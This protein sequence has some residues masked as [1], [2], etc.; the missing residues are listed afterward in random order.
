MN[1]REC[2]LL[3][4]RV[5]LD[6]L[7]QEYPEPGSAPEASARHWRQMRAMVADPQGWYRRRTR[8]VWRRVLRTAAM[9]A[10]TLAVGASAL[11]AASPTIRAA[12]L[13]WVRTT[14][15]VVTE[16]RFFGT[17]EESAL[18]RY[19]PAWLPEGY[20]L[21]EETETEYSRSFDYTDDAGET[22]WIDYHLLDD[23]IGETIS[24]N[25]QG[26]E[27][28]WVNGL[29]ADYYAGDA[30]SPMNVLIWV[31]EE[32]EIVFSVGSCLDKQA[33][34]HIAKSLSLEDPTN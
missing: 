20:V 12:A 16:Y 27:T 17:A 9:V 10:L 13:R 8:P 22:I 28:V 32:K 31:D 14:Y 15:G 29:P 1:D 25:E 34:L 30:D 11:L 33:I 18:S 4:R 6:A 3:L 19:V 2:D 7:E 26:I 23:G 21:A 5:L 24:G